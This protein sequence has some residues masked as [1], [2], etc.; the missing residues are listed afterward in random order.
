MTD[1]RQ[2][3]DITTSAVDRVS[4]AGTALDVAI[5]RLNGQALFNG[6]AT[7][8][9]G[10]LYSQMAEFDIIT[11]QTKYEKTLEQYLDF[12]Q[13]THA[14][15]SDPTYSFGH[16][17]ARAYTAYK[18]PIFLQYAIQSWWFGR[19]YTLSDSDVSAGKIATKNFPISGVCTTLNDT[20][21]TMAGG[22]FHDPRE[23]CCQSSWIAA[24]S[25]GYFLLL[26]AL[27]A[28]ATSDPM[29]LQA[30]TQSADFIRAH[31]SG[32][33]NIVQEYILAASN[34]SCQVIPTTFPSMTPAAS[35]L[36]IEGLAILYSVTNNAPTQSLLNDL[37]VTVIPNIDWQGDNGV[38]AYQ[39][40]STA[41]MGDM[42]LLQGLGAV[43]TRKSTT[44]ALLQYIGAYIAV[45][46]NAVTDLAT[47]SGTNIY[48]GSWTGPP[49]TD[50]LGYNQTAAL[51]ALLSAISLPMT[52]AAYPPPSRRAAILGGGVG[53]GVAVLTAMAVLGFFRLRRQRIGR[54]SAL[55][56]ASLESGMNPSTE[57]TP[58]GAASAARFGPQNLMAEHTSIPAGHPSGS[59]SGPG[60]LS[61]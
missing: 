49:S 18:N 35:G 38:I 51:A 27:L 42:N 21:E 10:Y 46:F 22:S 57:T 41:T 11:N 17:A 40:S 44:A 24:T 39:I 36:M 15:F 31:L 8:I 16:A 29:Y 58:T 5:G 3:S 45:Q 30:A 32:P 2:K 60:D 6:E 13:K 20:L 33:R 43:Y 19:A 50:F 7:G 14:N 34:D 55:P 12:I 47:P 26:S 61:R 54:P 25:T 9:A 37:L 48:A 53:G 52:A 56:G 23:S 4:L 59:V 28:E 1:G